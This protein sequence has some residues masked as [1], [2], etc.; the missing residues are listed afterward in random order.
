MSRTQQVLRGIAFVGFCLF[1]VY[2]AVVICYCTRAY[3]ANGFAGVLGWLVH[4][5]SGSS[6]AS[7]GEFGPP[8][9][10][11]AGVLG[12]LLTALVITILL[13]LASRPVPNIV[14]RFTKQARTSYDH[15]AVDE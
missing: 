5:S 6:G 12:R 7:A 13:G 11:T 15:R 14:W 9:N 10:P 8:T 4:V 3:A 1:L 2:W